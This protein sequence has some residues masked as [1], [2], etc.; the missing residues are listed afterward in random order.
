VLYQLSYTRFF[1][2]EKRTG[3]MLGSRPESSGFSKIIRRAIQ[4]F[5]NSWK[6]FVSRL[7]LLAVPIFKFIHVF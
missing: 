2:L 4:A 6:F 1:S 5:E 3:T 7:G